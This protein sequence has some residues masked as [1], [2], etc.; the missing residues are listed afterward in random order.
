MRKAMLIGF[1]A[2]GL[3]GPVAAYAQSTA[4]AP[5]QPTKVDVSIDPQWL[6]IGAG[7]VV[8]AVV[9]N[10]AVDTNLAYVI[11]GVVGGY[12]ADLWYSGHDVQIITTPKS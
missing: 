10:A 2:V 9:L 4:P 3:A 8:G 12:L 7:V 11:G 1:L 5:A 6:V